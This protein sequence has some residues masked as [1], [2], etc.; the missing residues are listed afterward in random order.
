MRKCSFCGKKI[1]KNEKICPYCFEN[2]SN[3]NVLIISLIAFIIIISIILILLI[4]K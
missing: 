4:I 2:Q 1:N 3:N